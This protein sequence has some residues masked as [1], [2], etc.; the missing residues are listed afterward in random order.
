LN[1]AEV[2][3]WVLARV[4]D[5]VRAIVVDN[6]STDGS[7][8]IA[9]SLGATVVDCAQRGYGAACRAGIAAATAEF[10]AFCDCDA[11]LDPA[12]LLRLAVVLRQG[13]DLVVAQRLPTGPGASPQHARL[14]NRE[15]ARRV[16]GHTGVPLPDL[17]PMRLARREA[18]VAL[19]RSPT[20]VAGIPSRR[21]CGWRAPAGASNRSTCRTCLG[22]APRR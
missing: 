14:A 10:V 15:L 11:T 16:R 21:S 7:A 20:R 9:R 4:P 12:D 13:A 8:R 5:G 18:Y 22:W 17:G 1:E 3:P 19:K 2:L 6:G